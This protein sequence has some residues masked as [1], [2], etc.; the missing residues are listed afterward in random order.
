MGSESRTHSVS[1]TE[2]EHHFSALVEPKVNLLGFSH[3]PCKGKKWRGKLLGYPSGY[4]LASPEKRHLL[5]QP[6]TNASPPLQHHLCSGGETAARTSIP[7][8]WALD[9]GRVSGIRDAT[10]ALTDLLA[11]QDPHLKSIK[12]PAGSVAGSPLTW[13]VG[14]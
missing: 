10:R 11:S 5:S 4:P 14:G 7:S 2:H 1:R 12:Q 8:P 3:C 9:P 6:G 13:G